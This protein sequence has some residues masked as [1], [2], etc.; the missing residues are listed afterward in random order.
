MSFWVY[1]LEC[2]DES[3]YMRHTDDLEKPLSEHQ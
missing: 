1:I 2:A 3:Y